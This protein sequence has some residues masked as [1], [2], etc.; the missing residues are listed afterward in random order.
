MRRVAKKAKRSS[1]A[2]ERGEHITAS[3]RRGLPAS[4]FALPPGPEEKSQG[5]AGRV[6]MDT[7]RRAR[8]GLARL[9]MMRH[10]GAISERELASA[11]ARILRKWPSI[12]R[13]R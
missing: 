4:E 6:P 3:G 7:I 10:R 8:V 11:R 13:P 9:S 2:N 12:D 5:F 1:A